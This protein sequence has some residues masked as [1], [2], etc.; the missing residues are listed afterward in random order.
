MK[1]LSPDPLQYGGISAF[2]VRL[3]SG[4]TT[5]ETV[6]KS[7]IERISALNPKLSAFVYVAEKA[8]LE[9]ARGIDRLLSGGTDLGPLMGVPV[10]VKDLFTVEGM[11]TRA[12]SNLEVADLISPEGRFVK[13]LKRAGCVILGKTRTTEF[14][15]GAQN[16]MHPTPWNPW[17]AK[18]QRTPGGSS[19]GS[20]VAQSAGLSAFAVGS[21]TGGSVRLPAALC[22][23]FG[24]KT[25][26]GIWPL[27]GVFPLCPAMDTIGLLTGSA[28]D[29]ALVFNT[30][31]GVP[32]PSAQP[33][34]GLRIGRPSDFFF[35]DLDPEVQEC[36]DKAMA[37]MES[38]GVEFINVEFPEA[39]EAAELFSK[40]VPADLVATLGSERVREG[41]DIMDP[42]AIDRISGGMD[43]K[44]VEYIQMARRQK[45]VE[46]IGLR[47]MSGL[48]AWI[49]PTTP[50]LPVPVH[51]CKSVERAVMFNGRALR[52]TRIGNMYGFCAS[53]IPIHG[54]GGKLPVGIQ[55]HCRPN[56]EAL[57]LSISL[58][59]ENLIGP[60]DKPDIGALV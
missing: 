37:Q 18:D 53:T 26:V 35:D 28:A 52:N 16:V 30:L 40:M 27:D 54:P 31:T 12:G 10:A 25:S 32:I 59:I 38:A 6:T 5:S 15:A 42:V 46:Q 33:L 50:T 22:G 48:E 45:D 3:R 39:G 11:P 44:A 29:A 13:A 1:T 4:E 60:Q 7:Y 23:I 56:R 51:S 47:R 19:S 58:A 14:A 34:K 2:A 41:R 20:A 36:V 8:A 9:T 21:D 55:I 43:M 17:D 49:A 57:L 24:L